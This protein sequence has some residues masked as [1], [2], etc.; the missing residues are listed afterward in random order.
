MS[1]PE[2]R[3]VVFGVTSAIAEQT[4]RHLA[5]GGARLFLVARDPE[6]L[7][8]IRDDLIQRGATV[9]GTATADLDDVARHPGLIQSAR[10]ALCGIDLVLVAHGILAESEACERDAAILERVLRTNFVGAAA[11]C[12]AAAL[13]LATHGGGVLIALSSVAGDRVRP[14]NYAYGAAKGGLSMFLAGLDARFHAQGVRVVTVKPGRVDTPMTAHLPP[15]GLSVDPRVVA[16]AILRVAAGQRPFVYVPWF[17]RGI[18]LVF[19]AL[20]P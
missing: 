9:A 20:P 16:R 18:R 1:E 4:A 17:W 12:Q 13:D 14:A 7:G 19:R 3:A 6:R 11:L 8:S 10:E 5:S 2:R 15:S